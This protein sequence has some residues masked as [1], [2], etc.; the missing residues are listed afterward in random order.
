MKMIL[1]LIFTFC[2][3]IL[4]H[5]ASD[6]FSIKEPTKWKVVENMFGMPYSILGPNQNNDGRAVITVSPIAHKEFPIDFFRKT[7]YFSKF[8]ENKKKWAKKVG[9]SILR[10]K[11]ELEPN[12]AEIKNSY[13]IEVS[14]VMNKKGFKEKSYYL[15]CRDKFYIIKYLIPLAIITDVEDVVE[16]SVLSFQC[17]E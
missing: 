4:G 2:L 8:K 5:S 12:V 9:G 15:Q 1:I 7:D 16:K 14:Y 10:F 17:K 11:H 13:A 6:G 3:T